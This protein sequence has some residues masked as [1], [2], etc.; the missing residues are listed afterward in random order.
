M[1]ACRTGLAPHRLVEFKPYGEVR[2]FLHTAPIEL[3][4]HHRHT[5]VPTGN[6]EHQG[7][8]TRPVSLTAKQVIA[9]ASEDVRYPYRAFAALTRLTLVD[10]PA[11]MLRVFDSP[12]RVIF[13]T[14]NVEDDADSSAKLALHHV[15]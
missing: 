10:G 8:Q 4:L 3:I 12:A 9:L 14:I 6:L 7:C 5:L 1:A 13:V 2:Q 11:L 15:G